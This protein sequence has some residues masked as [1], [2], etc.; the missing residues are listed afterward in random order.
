MTTLETNGAI[1]HAVAPQGPATARLLFF[2]ANRRSGTTWLHGMLNAHPEIIMRNEGWFLNDIGCSA[3]QWLDESTFRVWAELPSTKG[4][5]LAG[6]TTDEAI[7]L[8]QRAM[9]SAIM[10]HS[11]TKDTWKNMSKIKWIGDK[12]TTHYTAKID[13]LHRLFPDACF[14]C[15]I[16]DGRD[17]VVSD[18]FLHLRDRNFGAYPGKGAE[19]ARRAYARY[20]EENGPDCPFF[21]EETLGKLLDGWIRSIE[22]GMRARELYQDAYYEIKYEDLVADPKR[23]KGILDFLGVK[24]DANIVDWIIDTC[25]FER[26]AEGRQRGQQDPRSEFRKGIIGDWRNYF[27][28]RDKEQFKASRA[29]Q[30]LIELGYEANNDW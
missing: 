6:T 2:G 17:V 26:F 13:T 14:L 22:G 28:D 18:H 4:N 1:A 8:V 30:L 9:V 5:W 10:R 11:A 20:F 19:D 21:T 25:R 27:N 3:E 12:T 16:R 15:M 7:T 29:G 23:L 24:S